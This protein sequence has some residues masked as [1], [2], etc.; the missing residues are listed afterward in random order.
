MLKVFRQVAGLAGPREDIGAWYDLDGFS[1]ISAKLQVADRTEAA[2]LALRQ[3][4]IGSLCRAIGLQSTSDS[5]LDS[6]AC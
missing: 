3:G 1:H 2:A 5:A 4:I 6:R